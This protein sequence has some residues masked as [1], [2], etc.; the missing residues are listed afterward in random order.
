M[1]I[2]S[3]RATEKGSIGSSG[4]GVENVGSTTL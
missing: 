3:T 1:N 4:L 2:A